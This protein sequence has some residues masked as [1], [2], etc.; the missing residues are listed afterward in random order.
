MSVST[1]KARVGR[2]WPR[3]PAD[4]QSFRYL[5]TLTVPDRGAAVRTVVDQLLPRACHGQRVAAYVLITHLVLAPSGA[6]FHAELGR[7]YLAT[8]A[9]CAERTVS[10]ML[11]A[12]RSARLIHTPRR[13]RQGQGCSIMAASAALLHMVADVARSAGA[14]RR[15]AGFTRK[16]QGRR[17]SH[18]ATPGTNDTPSRFGSGGKDALAGPADPDAAPVGARQ[19]AMAAIRAMLA[20]PQRP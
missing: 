14:A 17:H 10:T 15:G 1:V 20:P 19:A 9:G 3:P 13:G 16:Q 8:Q 18:G 11:A 7:G 2:F 4:R 6:G 5:R 12:L